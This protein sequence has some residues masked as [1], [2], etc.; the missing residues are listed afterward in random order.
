VPVE[1]FSEQELETAMK[2]ALEQARKLGDRA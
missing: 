2:A 1:T